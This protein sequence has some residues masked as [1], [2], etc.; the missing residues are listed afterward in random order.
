MTEVSLEGG[1]LL[2]VGAVE[3]GTDGLVLVVVGVGTLSGRGKGEGVLGGLE[4]GLGGLADGL[5]PG[6]SMGE[7]RLRGPGVTAL[8]AV[9]G[10]IGVGIVW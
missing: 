3:G 9:V 2:S 8:D 10:S 5:S 7:G 4:G 6:V 1:E